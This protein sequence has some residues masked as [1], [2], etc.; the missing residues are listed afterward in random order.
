MPSSPPTVALLS[1]EGT[2]DRK[3]KVAIDVV[4]FDLGGVL[5][6]LGGVGEL[7]R[8]VGEPSEDILWRRWLSCPW[9]RRFERGQCSPDEFS[10]GMVETWD[11]AL[12]PETFL[13]VFT[14]WPK[15]FY[16]G[17]RELVGSLQGRARTACLS[18]TNV[19]HTQLEWSGTSVVELFED[20]FLSH[21]MGCV[22]PD[23]EAFDHAVSG[24]GCAAGRILFL[25]DNVI[26][27]E[28][29]RSAG[30]CAEITRG[31]SEAR[32]ALAAYGLE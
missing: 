2:T 21:E 25:D 14:A 13:E 6:E 16:P 12:S 20:C 9:V 28:A 24:L 22:K 32:R 27:V 29:A 17:A 1:A 3:P 19:L 18:N 31:P 8:L 7:G 30:L 23:R 26:N 5:I 4:L 10:N 11:L 15:G